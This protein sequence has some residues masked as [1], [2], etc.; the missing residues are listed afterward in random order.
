MGID[1]E[2]GTTTIKNYRDDQHSLAAEKGTLIRVV[3]EPKLSGE[4][5]VSVISLT[6]CD[7]PVS[8]AY[9]RILS[10]RVM[11]LHDERVPSSDLLKEFTSPEKLEAPKPAES[12][13]D[14]VLG[15]IQKHAVP[16]VG[17]TIDKILD[18]IGS[19]FSKEEVESQLK[20]SLNDGTLLTTIDDNHIN[21]L[22]E[23]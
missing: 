21:I 7:K 12:L 3:G 14:T 5:Y 9:H 23:S 8:L 13:K 2:T 22:T 20:D 11:L 10:V 15:A 1:D 4:F 17:V 18:A 19:R 6:V 16:D